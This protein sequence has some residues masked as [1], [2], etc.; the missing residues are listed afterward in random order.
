MAMG[1]QCAKCGYIQPEGPGGF[2][3]ECPKCGAVYAKVEAAASEA[4]ATPESAPAAPEVQS[5][6]VNPPGWPNGYVS[7]LIVIAILAMIASAI[8]TLFGASSIL[9][10]IYFLMFTVAVAGLTIV[11]AIKSAAATIR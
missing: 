9:T 7:T 6:F 5:V 11:Q 10:A 4:A 8:S 2:E 1:K 3:P